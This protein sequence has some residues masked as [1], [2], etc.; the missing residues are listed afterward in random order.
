MI[1][2]INAWLKKHPDNDPDTSQ[3]PGFEITQGDLIKCENAEKYLKKN[4][5][6]LFEEVQVHIAEIEQ[7]RKEAASLYKDSIKSWNAICRDLNR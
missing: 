7:L 3:L 6:N 1:G 4:Q 2:T 5:E